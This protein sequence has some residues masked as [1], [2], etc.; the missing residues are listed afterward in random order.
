MVRPFMQPSYRGRTFAI[1]S[2]GAIQ[3]F[4]GPASSFLSL[5]MKVRCSVRATSVGLL[6]WKKQF[7]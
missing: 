7:G 2:A 4:V 1:A 5:Q 6:R 3:L